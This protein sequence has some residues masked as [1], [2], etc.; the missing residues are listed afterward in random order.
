MSEQELEEIA[1]AI[2]YIV[3]RFN[4]DTIN[5]LLREIEK[6]KKI[7]WVIWEFMSDKIFKDKSVTQ[8]IGAPFRFLKTSWTNFLKDQKTF[9]G[10]EMR[11]GNVSII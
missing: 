2:F 9:I 3:R 8:G 10:A 7:D 1:L 4:S 5:G 11:G 6:Y